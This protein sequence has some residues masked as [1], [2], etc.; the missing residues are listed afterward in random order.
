MHAMSRSILRRGGTYEE[1]YVPDSVNST[2]TPIR[3][4]YLQATAYISAFVLSL[5][6]PVLS[7]FVGYNYWISCAIAVMVPSQGVFNALIFVSHKIY[8]HRRI[9]KEKSNWEIFRSLFRETG[10]ADDPVYI[11]R[12]TFVH[13][14]ITNERQALD[15]LSVQEDAE[16]NNNQNVYDLR[17]GETNDPSMQLASS[18]IFPIQEE[19]S[20]EDLNSFGMLKDELPEGN[21]MGMPSCALDPSKGEIS[22]KDH[23]LALNVI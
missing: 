6:F 21:S 1:N 4:V 8:K 15:F 3:V 12:L 20:S 18:S 23:C 11:S 10:A 22:C 13:A 5:M 2:L 17:V 9:H 7:A 14:D 16:D 19:R